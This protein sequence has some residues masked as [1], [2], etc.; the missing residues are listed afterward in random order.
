MSFVNGVFALSW[1]AKPGV[2][3]VVLPHRHFP[4]GYVVKVSG[5]RV[6]SKPGATVLRLRSTGPGNAAVSVDRR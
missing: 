3:E 4:R 5:A 2:T 1:R 6:V